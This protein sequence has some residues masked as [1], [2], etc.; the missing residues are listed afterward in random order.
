M[1][2]L[3]PIYLIKLIISYIKELNL[4]FYYR[5]TVKGL[6]KSG[7]LEKTGLRVDALNRIFFVKNLDAEVLLYGEQEG[8]LDKFEKG[9]VA[10]ELRKYN[11]FFIKNQLIELVKTS[12]KRIK[13]SEYY[14]YLVL[15]F[16]NFTKVTIFETL[17]ILSY[18]GA[19]T[20]GVIK[21][22]QYKSV[23]LNFLTV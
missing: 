11:E 4:F 22:I 5:N 14:A 13:T 10:E 6:I 16:F 1:K 19:V 17:Y 12:L 20:F 9:F 7:E 18:I 21:F 8:G 2:R 15:I 23:L 3:S